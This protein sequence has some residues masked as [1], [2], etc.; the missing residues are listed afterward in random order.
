MCGGVHYGAVKGL[1]SM[2]RR[3]CNRVVSMGICTHLLN[4][5]TDHW[6]F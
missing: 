1:V 2:H 6:P 3:S 5:V 4:A